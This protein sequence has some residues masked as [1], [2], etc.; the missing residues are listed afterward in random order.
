MFWLAGA[1]N[2]NLGIWNVSSGTNMN[3]MFSSGVFNQNIG[4]WDVGSATVMIKMFESASA[5]NQNIGSWN[6]SN[7]TDMTDMFLNVTLS[8]ANYGAL[9]IGWDALSLQN[10]VTFHGG[11]SQYSA[12]AA[13]TARSN[14]ITGDSWTITDGGQVP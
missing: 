12:G 13:T 3:L 10:S 1:F 2:Q 11:N 6:V 9:L 14:I 4:S 5:F 8:T 7:V